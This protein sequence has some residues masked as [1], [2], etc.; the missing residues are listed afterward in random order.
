MGIASAIFIFS[1]VYAATAQRQGGSSDDPLFLTP[2]LDN[3]QIQQA[4]ALSQV[5]LRSLYRGVS[6]S[7]FITADR[8]LG[9]HLF[10]WHFPARRDSNA[11][12]VIWMNGGPGISSL[13]G[14]FHEN[15]PIQAVQNRRGRG[16]A[17][18]RTTTWVDSFSMLYV[19]NPTT[20]GFS[21]TDSGKAGR[22]FTQ[23]G[24][25]DDLYSFLQQFYVM[26]PEY[27]TRELYIGGQSYAGK[28]TIALAKRV[29]LANLENSNNR[30]PLRGVYMG[31]PLFDPKTQ[32]TTIYDGMLSIGAITNVFR[33]EIIANITGLIDD[34]EAGTMELDFF[35]QLEII[36]PPEGLPGLTG[37]DNFFTNEVPDGKFESILNDPRVKRA[38]HVGNREWVYQSEFA[39]EFGEDF[40][41]STKDDLATFLLDV[42]IKVLI[43]NGNV[44]LIVNTKAVEVALAR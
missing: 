36:A 2:Y 31:G 29:H 4:R 44:D 39:N 8:T 17:A 28:Y 15:G 3:G 11:P 13:L 30:L 1:L 25:T 38:I 37:Y 42:G 18:P 14:L 6:Y 12:L 27:L 43:Y 33:D 20:A 9:N 24:Y 19:D 10:F 5:S 40:L 23:E 35:E 41:V 7:G 16:R 32:I 21:F 26:F 34:F 22:K